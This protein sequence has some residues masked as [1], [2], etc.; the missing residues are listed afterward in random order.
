MVMPKSAGFEAHVEAFYRVGQGADR[1]VVD[2]AFAVLSEG[3]E[4]YASRRFDFNASGD[5]LDSFAGAVGSEVV[6]HYAVDACGE[7]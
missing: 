3:V 5:V 7:S 2:S 6:E 1:D 4:G